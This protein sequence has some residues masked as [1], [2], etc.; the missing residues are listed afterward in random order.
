VKKSYE[1]MMNEREIIRLLRNKKHTKKL[2][3]RESA[4]VSNQKVKK[5]LLIKIPHFIVL[6]KRDKNNRLD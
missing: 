5:V 3:L 6:I 4:C 1:V 2:D